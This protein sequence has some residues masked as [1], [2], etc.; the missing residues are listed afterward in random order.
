MIGKCLMGVFA[1]IFAHG[2]ISISY[3]V[4]SARFKDYDFGSE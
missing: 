3:T 4:M 1:L 2:N